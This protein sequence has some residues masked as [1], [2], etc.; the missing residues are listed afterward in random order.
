MSRRVALCSHFAI[1]HYRGGEKWVVCVA[2]RLAA[3]GFDVD[4]YALGYAPGGERRVEARDVLD[5]SV[6]YTEGWRH[7]VSGY[8]TAYVMYAPGMGLC[9]TH[10]PE[11]RS[12]AGIHSWAFI[13]DRL[14]ESHY[15][16]VPTAAKLCYRAT[17]TRELRQYDAVHT[18]SPVYDS[19]HPETTYVPNFLD[20]ETYRP[21]REPLAEEFTVLVTAAHIE[22]KGWDDVQQV[23]DRLS[24]DIRV[25][26][27]GDPDHPHV[28]ALGF[29]DEAEL[30]DA[31]ARSHVVLHPTRVD[32]DSMVINEALA[33][34]T[35]V[36]TSPLSTHIRRDEAVLHA[37]STA[38]FVERII[39]L[40]EEVAVDPERYATRCDLAR[41]HGRNRDT[42]LVYR[43]LRRLLFP[44]W[45]PATGT[46]R[47]A[48]TVV[49]EGDTTGGDP[50]TAVALTETEAID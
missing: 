16:V 50:A 3:D 45:E 12:V 35:P 7:D 29:L 39:D 9:F 13:T 14:V 27:T 38:A 26:A 23:T 19:P 42:D 28:D 46:V 4:V 18:V 6:A 44:D 2:N 22:E 40:H 47:E 33:S 17:G 48:D 10:G 32:T 34:G 31:Y 36:L 20:T 21:D 30:A 11:T 15:G 41:Q 43:R 8:D 49:S 37:N 5:D 1:D 24:P 25:A